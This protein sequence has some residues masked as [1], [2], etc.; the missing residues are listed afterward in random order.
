MGKWIISGIVFFLLSGCASTAAPPTTSSNTSNSAPTATQ[1]ASQTPER[2]VQA[3][4]A[5]GLEAENDRAMAREDYG[6]APFVCEGRRFFMP[7]IPPGDMSGRTFVCANE[8]DLT[9]LKEYYDS[10]GRSSAMFFSHTFRK[11]NVLLQ[12]AGD[13]PDDQAKQYEAA[14][15]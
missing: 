6:A 1:A 4:K 7:S 15:P 9:S 2:V 8:T 14:L 10:L 11:G 13:V 12:M 5:K 3:F